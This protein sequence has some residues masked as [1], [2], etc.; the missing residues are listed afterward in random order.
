ML[1]VCSGLLG[2]QRAASVDRS[3]R[4]EVNEINQVA[5]PPAQQTVAIVGAT[6]IDGRGGR[7][8]K[9]SVV[10]VKGTR[11]VY[12]GRR[13]GAAIPAGVRVIDANGLTLLPGLID[14]HFHIDGDDLAALFLAHGVTSLR[15]PGQWIEKYKAARA[16]SSPLPRLFLAGP[17][18]DSPP[19]AFPTDS[20]L[21]RD[22]DEARNAV[23]SFADQGA[24]VIK[25][26][27]RLPLGLIRVAT[28]TAHAR[29]LPV[30]A[31]LEIVSATDAIAVGVDGIEHVTSLGTSLVPPRESEKYRQ[32]VLADNSARD[33]GRY[34]MWSE[35]DVNSPQAIALTRL[36]AKRG[37]FLSATLAAFE[38]RQGDR[39][40]TDVQLRG[41]K[42]MVAFV[43]MAR[44]EGVRV[45]VGSHGTVRHAERGWAYQR[46]MEMLVEAG[47]T[48]MEAI[49]AATMENARFFRIDKRLGSIERGKIADLVLVDGDPLKDIKTMRRIKRVMLNGR[50]VLGE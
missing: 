11:F 9:D 30:T 20:F 33:P 14:A 49:V 32:A 15:D 47:L 26:Y 37:I 35:I 45:V 24:S 28:K 12:A 25:V 13:A 42:N 41:Y 16:A 8:L 21:V 7:P 50:W 39:G 19:P 2:Q 10:I 40:I 44:R 22:A 3:A 5:R 1:L 18:L 27:F 6:L 29:G 43:G 46:E 36:M 48:S 31:H 4:P 38:R 34:E 23:N 17:H